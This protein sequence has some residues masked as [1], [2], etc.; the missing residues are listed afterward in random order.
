MGFCTS[1]FF[2]TITNRRQHSKLTQSSAL[3]LWGFALLSNR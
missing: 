1:I 3:G 2:I